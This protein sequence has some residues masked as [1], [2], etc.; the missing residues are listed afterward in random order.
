MTH[1]NAFRAGDPDCPF[2]LPKLCASCDSA[3]IPLQFLPLAAAYAPAWLAM[4]ALKRTKTDYWLQMV[5]GLAL[6][7]STLLMVGY[8]YGRLSGY[9]YFLI[10]NYFVSIR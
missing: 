6:M 9:P 7:I 2:C 5:A 8:I 4:G 10:A 3:L 1:C